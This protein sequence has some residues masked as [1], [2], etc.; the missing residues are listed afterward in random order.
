MP[1]YIYAPT[2]KYKGLATQDYLGTAKTR[3][4]IESITD[5]ALRQ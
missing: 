5:Q 4:I 3:F 2:Y 1:L